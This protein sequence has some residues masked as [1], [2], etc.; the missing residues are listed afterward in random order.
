MVNGININITETQFK[1]LSV[2]DQNWMMF[3]GIE[4]I[5]RTGCSFGRETH[6]KETFSKFIVMSGAFGAALGTAIGIWAFIAK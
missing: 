6:K 2:A 1:E 5:D 4:K 3:K